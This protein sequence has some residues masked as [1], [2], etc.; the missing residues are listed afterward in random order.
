MQRKT[1]RN[2]SIPLRDAGNGETLVSAS[3]SAR[4]VGGAHDENHPE[5]LDD[6][7]HCETRPIAFAAV[8]VAPADRA[9]LLLFILFLV[10]SGKVS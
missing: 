3:D 10:V 2:P 7:H 4:G 5:H 1:E 9:R 8:M 6:L